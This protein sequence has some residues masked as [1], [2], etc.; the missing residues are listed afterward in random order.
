MLLNPDTM[1]EIF[2]LEHDDIK[3][4]QDKIQVALPVYRLKKKNHIIDV[5][6]LVNQPFGDV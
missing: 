6:S 2:L 3:Y 4:L 1:T 5:I